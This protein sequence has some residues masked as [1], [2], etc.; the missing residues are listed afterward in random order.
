MPVFADLC[1][2]FGWQPSEIWELDVADLPLWVE[3]MNRQI[4]KGYSKI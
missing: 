1:W 3:Q 4:K 2:W